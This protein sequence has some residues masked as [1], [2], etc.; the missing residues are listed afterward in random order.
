VD[1]SFYD[2]PM[3]D[4]DLQPLL[5]TQPSVTERYG[6]VARGTGCGNRLET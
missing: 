1:T 4:C 3:S 5:H 6:T 2:K